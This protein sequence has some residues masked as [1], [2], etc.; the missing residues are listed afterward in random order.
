M[1]VAGIIGA[2]GVVD[3]PLELALVKKK[4]RIFEILAANRP[5]ERLLR[6]D[7]DFSSAESHQ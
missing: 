4:R 3:C 2:D 6:A 5:Q 1:R 7:A